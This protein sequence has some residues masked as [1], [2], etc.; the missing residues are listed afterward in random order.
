M[1]GLSPYRPFLPLLFAAVVLSGCAGKKNANQT[2]P[3]AWVDQRPISESHYI[4]I[5]SALKTMDASEATKTAKERAAADLAAEIAVRVESTSLLESAEANGSV[6][7]HFSSSISSRAEERISGFE[8]VDAWEDEKRVHVYYRLNKALHASQRQARRAEAMQS[9]ALEYS[10]GRTARDEGNLLRALAHWSHGVMVLEE[11]WN[12]VNRTE[13]EGQEVNLASHL[14]RTLRQTVQDIRLEP[15]VNQVKLTAEGRFKFP[16]GLEATIAQ[17]EQTGV[18]IAYAYHNGTYRRS[19]TEF[20]DDHGQVVALISD[21]AP[22]RPNPNFTAGIDLERLWKQAE[23]DPTVVALCGSPITAEISVPI[24]VEMPRVHVGA[25]AES[26]L[27]AGQMAGPIEAL[28]RV[29]MKE[30]FEVV[31]TPESAQFQLSFRLRS[32]MRSPQGDLANFHTAYVEGIALTRDATG[33]R[34]NETQI[35]RIKGVQLN[36]EAAL[37]IALSNLAESIEKSLGKKITDNLR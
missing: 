8:V 25:D 3:P 21:V 29:L 16:L 30:G 10:A 9:A 4:G 26:T 35:D 27:D 11:F 24:K 12:E 34:V 37:R 23:V 6:S 5:G 32:D 2:P 15:A 28:R 22:R 33:A 18:P 17:Q 31:D 14:V 19:G 7:E 13:V 20:T 1:S 36:A